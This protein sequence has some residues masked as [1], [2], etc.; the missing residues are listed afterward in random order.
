MYGYIQNRENR[1]H[2]YRICYEFY[3]KIY[4]RLMNIDIFPRILIFL[5]DLE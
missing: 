5:Y 4:G 3:F 1:L 2:I